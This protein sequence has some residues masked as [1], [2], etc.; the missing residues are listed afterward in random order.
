MEAPKLG[1]TK[2]EILLFVSSISAATQLV[3][4]VNNIAN[5]LLGNGYA[6]SK[7]VCER[8]LAEYASASGNFTSVILRVGQ[9]CGLVSSTN[10]SSW[11]KTEWVPSFV[12]SSRFIGAVPLSL[13]LNLDVVDWIPID[14]IGNIVS[15]LVDRPDPKREQNEE[16]FSIF[17]LVHPPL[18]SWSNLLPYIVSPSE[19][20]DR[21]QNSDQS[22]HVIHQNLD[23]GIIYF[24]RQTILIN[25]VADNVKVKMDNTLHVSKTTMVMEPINV[26]HMVRWM[27]GWGL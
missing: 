17:N 23:P 15:E 2:P 13:G 8:M 11:N 26:R 10:I 7:Y 4:S 12:I 3:L 27:E 1:R 6:R 16:P 9:V 25:K 20:I 5:G 19:W 21:L 18:I 14:M 22:P 24:Y